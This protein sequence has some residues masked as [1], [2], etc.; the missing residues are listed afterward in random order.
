MK[1]RRWHRVG[2]VA[3]VVWI[4][5]AGSSERIRQ[6]RLAGEIAIAARDA[7]GRAR[8]R[9]VDECSEVFH[10]VWKEQHADLPWELVAYEAFAPVVGAWL[11]AGLGLWVYRWIMSGD[12]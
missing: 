11:L 8:E 3:S 6:T 1:L 9:S 5:Y 12:R 7:C 2:I 4:L 10:R